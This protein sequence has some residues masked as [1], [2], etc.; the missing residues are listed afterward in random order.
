MGSCL[1]L[2]NEW[3]EETHGLTKQEIPLGRTPGQRAGDQRTQESSSTHGSHVQASW[4]LGRFLGHLWP[5]IVSKGPSRWCTHL[6]VKRDSSE[7]SGGLV[8]HKSWH[9]LSP[10]DFSQFLPV[11]LCSWPRRPVKITRASGYCLAWSD[12]QSFPNTSFPLPPGSWQF[13]AY[14]PAQ[15]LPA[16]YGRL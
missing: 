11:V 10:F 16:Q 14:N 12:F 5:I 3:S 4:Y 2:G 15:L 6:S 8:G 7:D 13:F 1:T 9:L